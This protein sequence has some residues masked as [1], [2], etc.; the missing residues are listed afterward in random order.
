M[1][2]QSTRLEENTD[3]Y[4]RFD[5][6]PFPLKLTTFIWHMNNSDAVLAGTEKPVLSQVGPFVYKFV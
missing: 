2:L 4:D 5:I 1:S 6:T 3:Q